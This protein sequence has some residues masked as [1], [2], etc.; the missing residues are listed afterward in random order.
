MLFIPKSFTITHPP[1]EPKFSM[2]NDTGIMSW[3]PCNNNEIN[4]HK[5][6]FDTQC[7]N[8]N[9]IRD[10]TETSNNNEYE[11]QSEP[12]DLVLQSCSLTCRIDSHKLCE[13]LS[14][15]MICTQNKKDDIVKLQNISIKYMVIAKIVSFSK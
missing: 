14:H 13:S 15:M 9:K 12:F 4:S 11:S 5:D 2:I 7:Y 1:L 10:T 8:G 6:E 3:I